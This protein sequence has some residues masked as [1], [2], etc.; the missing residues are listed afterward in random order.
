MN[1][2]VPPEINK[3]ER[4]QPNNQLISYSKQEMSGVSDEFAYVS[5]DN[6]Q[7]KSYLNPDEHCVIFTGPE[8]SK[9]KKS[10]QDKLINSVKSLRENDKKEFE[11]IIKDEIDTIIKEKK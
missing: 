6:P 11:K 2:Q 4:K 9:L 3:Q 7:P 5:I 10:D 8:G 1:V